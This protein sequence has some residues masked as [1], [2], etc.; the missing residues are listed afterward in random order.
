LDDLVNYIRVRN[1][2]GEI[3]LKHIIDILSIDY[4]Q[5]YSL[6]KTR[7]G[8]YEYPITKKGLIELI[9]ERNN[10]IESDRDLFVNMNLVKKY[11][12]TLN[13]IYFDHVESVKE[14]QKLNLPTCFLHP[15]YVKYFRHLLGIENDMAYKKAINK[16][17]K[18]KIF[19]TRNIIDEV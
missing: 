18:N 13:L 17:K 6:V 8:V 5:D 12:S 16:K 10:F 14:A 11:H 1:C 4:K 9:V 7:M 15:R 2:K 19:Y 3:E